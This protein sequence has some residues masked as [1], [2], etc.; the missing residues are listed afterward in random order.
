MPYTQSIKKEIQ[1]TGILKMTSHLTV[2][3]VDRL[4]MNLKKSHMAEINYLIDEIQ[5]LKTNIKLLE[6]S[7]NKD[8]DC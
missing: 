7:L 2:N 8:Y 6:A 5:K 4:V 3:G 1:E